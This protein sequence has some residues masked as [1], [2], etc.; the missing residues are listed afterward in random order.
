MARTRASTGSC[1]GAAAGAGGD[2]AGGGRNRSGGRRRERAPDRR[3]GTRPGR[4]GGAPRARAGAAG[5]VEPS[6]TGAAARPAFFTRK[7]PLLDLGLGG[8]VA[9][10]RREPGAE[11]GRVVDAVGE[12]ELLG[13]VA[14]PVR[15]AG[16]ARIRVMVI[17]EPK[18][19]PRRSAKSQS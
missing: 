6:A 1:A 14:P 3:G 13:R 8:V 2:R 16:R 17:C 9:A 10:D 7:R 5:G 12:A 15:A 11:A 19:A 4:S 18:P